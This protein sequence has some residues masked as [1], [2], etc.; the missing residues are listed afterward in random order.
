[1]T[2][3]IIQALFKI[4]IQLDMSKQAKERES[5][6]DLLNAV[7]K[8]KFLCLPYTKQERYFTEKEI[9]KKKRGWRGLNQKQKESFLTAFATAIK[10]DTTTS[11]RKYAYEL[12]V[13][14]ETVKTAIKQHFSPDLHL[15]DSDIWNVLGNKR[16]AISHPNIGSFKLLIRWNG[17][18]K[19][20][21]N[22]F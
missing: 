12:K 20:L 9:F 17:K 4:K 10:K 15:F 22:L 19:C 7:T 1:M 5:I 11:I 18:K 3:S 6:Y 2:S 13:H 8:P 16:N 21:K 14:E